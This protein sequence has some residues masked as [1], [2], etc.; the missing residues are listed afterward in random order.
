MQDYR[1]SVCEKLLF[2]IHGEA[3]VAVKCPRCKTLN[4]LTLLTKQANMN[5]CERPNPERP[6]RQ[7]LM[8]NLAIGRKHD[9]PNPKTHL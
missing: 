8:P 4:S 3:V 5:A 2:R 1:C 9:K 6:E 7:T